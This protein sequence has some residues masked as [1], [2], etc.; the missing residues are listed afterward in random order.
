[1]HPYI[2]PI[3][4]SVCRLFIYLFFYLTNNNYLYRFTGLW[5]QKVEVLSQVT[6]YVGFDV[7]LEWDFL[8]PDGNKTKIM[9][10]N[11]QHGTGVH[12]SHLR[13]RVDM[14]DHSLQIKNVELSDA[15]SY[16]CT[17]NTY[18]LGRFH[19][20]TELHVQDSEM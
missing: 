9:V 3:K 1:D 13:G 5:A 8:S 14:D 10:F 18:P 4:L 20:T 6:G 19:D 7:T 15:G 16:I 17:I 2:T 11:K 12:E